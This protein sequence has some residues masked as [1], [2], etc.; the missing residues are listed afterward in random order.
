MTNY[1]WPMSKSSDD[2]GESVKDDTVEDWR[3]NFIVGNF[4]IIDG[5]KVSWRNH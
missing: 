2:A 3:N 4:V 5:C 1:G